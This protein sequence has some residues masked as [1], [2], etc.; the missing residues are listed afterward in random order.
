[1]AGRFSV[2]VILIVMVGGLMMQATEPQPP[3]DEYPLPADPDLKPLDFPPLE[4]LPTVN[5]TLQER[6]KDQIPDDFVGGVLHEI[7]RTGH[8]VSDRFPTEQ[9][10]GLDSPTPSSNRRENARVAEQLL[11]SARLLENLKSD[12]GGCVDLVERLRVEASQ[13]LTE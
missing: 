10:L 9:D 8:S 11:K 3:I 1:M 13:L 2:L 7:L 5:E 4:P 12:D 6:L